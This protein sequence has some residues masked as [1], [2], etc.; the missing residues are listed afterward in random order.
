MSD[1]Y[2]QPNEHGAYPPD[3]CEVIAFEGRK[4]AA[5]I[6]LAHIGP[7]QWIISASATL[8]SRSWSGYPS[9]NR[10]SRYPSRLDALAAAANKIIADCVA[11]RHT[12]STQAEAMARKE[13]LAWA[14]HQKQLRLF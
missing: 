11:S 4:G 10:G 13:V 6:M 3:Q 1:T 14:E 2:S 8:G 7:N 5:R 12:T 9:A